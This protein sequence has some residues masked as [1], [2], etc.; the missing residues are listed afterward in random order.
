MMPRVS[1]TLSLSELQNM[2]DGKR[3]ELKKL[4]K[5]RAKQL[6]HLNKIEARIGL[7][8][9]NGTLPRV[10]GQRQQNETNLA[11]TLHQVLSKSSH[12]LGI[13]EISDRVEASGY[14]SSSAN[15]PGL[16]NVTLIKDKRFA[17]AERG[18][19]QLRL[20]KAANPS[21]QRKRKGTV[22]AADK[23]DGA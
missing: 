23:E 20:A 5:R 6:K 10:P 9:G 21:A 16:V 15:F 17:R 4:A 1:T 7:I 2:I 13:R 3:K 18:R 19:Y 14:K 22:T 12:P 8:S 11:D